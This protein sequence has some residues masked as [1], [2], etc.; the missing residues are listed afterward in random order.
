MESKYE[1][2]KEE[3]YE[4]PLPEHDI[5]DGSGEYQVARGEG[6]TLILPNDPSPVAVTAIVVGTPS[7]GY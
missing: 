1:T 4:G 2:I 6:L 5:D 7:P 3:Q